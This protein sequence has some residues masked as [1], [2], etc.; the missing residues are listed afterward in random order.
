ML[1]FFLNSARVYPAAT[2]Q[3]QLSIQSLRYNNVGTNA[4]DVTLPL[5]GVP[6]NCAAVGYL[7]RTEVSPVDA[8]AAEYTFRIESDGFTI[9]GPARI[10]SITHEAAV[11]QLIGEKIKLSGGELVL[12]KR[13]EKI[14]I[15]RVMLNVYA[16]GFPSGQQKT[17]ECE[18][19][20]TR[21]AAYNAAT[22]VGTP[23]MIGMLGYLNTVEYAAMYNLAADVCAFPTLCIT[24]KKDPTDGDKK[25]A[26]AEV[27]NFVK[28]A[29]Q[30]YDST[31]ILERYSFGPGKPPVI[32]PDVPGPI[33]PPDY[34]R[35]ETTMQIAEG[36]ITFTYKSPWVRLAYILELVMKHV[37]YTLLPDENPLRQHPRLSRLFA[38]LYDGV[39]PNRSVS[40][41]LDCLRVLFG[42][43]PYA[44]R[45]ADTDTTRYIAFQL[46]RED[47]AATAA[48]SD[49]TPA[50]SLDA[51]ALVA[52]DA[53]TVT[54][55]WQFNQDTGTAELQDN[56]RG[57]LD[58]RG[59]CFDYPF[60]VSGASG[61]FINP[62]VYDYPQAAS[63]IPSTSELDKATL[64]LS[65]H[66]PNS[67]APLSLYIAEQF[68]NR[69]D[70]TAKGGMYF[71]LLS[72]DFAGGGVGTPSELSIPNGLTYAPPFRSWVVPACSAVGFPDAT[73]Q[74]RDNKYLTRLSH[75]RPNVLNPA[76]PKTTITD[77]PWPLTADGKEVPADG[78]EHVAVILNDLTAVPEYQPAEQATP[79]YKV[80]S[81][82]AAGDYEEP[83]TGTDFTPYG[84]LYIAQTPLPEEFPTAKL[85]AVDS[86]TLLA[87]YTPA[88]LFT[89][90]GE[91]L[92]A[93]RVTCP[94]YAPPRGMGARLPESQQVKRLPTQSDK[95]STL[96]LATQSL[97][98]PLFLPRARALGDAGYYLQSGGHASLSA[99]ADQANCFL[100]LSPLTDL[101]AGAAENAQSDGG[102][103]APAADAPQ[104]TTQVD[105]STV[106][107]FT[108]IVPP[109]FDFNLERTYI[110][111]ARRFVAKSFQVNIQG[112]NIGETATGEFL[113]LL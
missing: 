43:V 85:L 79:L 69:L 55:Q 54:S 6:A 99:E 78:A 67:N 113:Q 73:I 74:G 96:D 31:D 100:S 91:T 97:P 70:A 82:G 37:G 52:A 27:R 41:F 89:T 108:F 11:L 106:Y 19:L 109:A 2:S 5:D 13:F 30:Y 88:E 101:P 92:D 56:Q 21:D 84:E 36:S 48:A 65:G 71:R 15:S 12:P 44:S 87:C 105:R 28:R 39:L 94:Y 95:F 110:I 18:P 102:D 57:A 77:N 34:H 53:H 50:A 17:Y 90:L 20:Y 29:Q 42:L 8:V 51:M 107:T 4:F 86:H 1:K 75:T 22:G 10:T 47:R 111:G 23:G 62:A 45:H 63:P 46:T 38:V 81:D 14:N 32:D 72:T 3:F 9:D 25:T 76:E 103:A 61:F 58:G 80:V 7:H 24:R 26:T 35:A 59:V 33:L 93:M 49:Q 64:Y 60:T 98:A 40:S 112:E 16:A 104:T 66:A 68:G 83:E